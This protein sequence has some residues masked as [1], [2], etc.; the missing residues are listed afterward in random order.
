MST[1]SQ[2]FSKEDLHSIEVMDLWDEAARIIVNHARPSFVRRL[3]ESLENDPDYTREAGLGL[4]L[5]RRGSQLLVK[6]ISHQ[7]QKAA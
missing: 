7:N 4:G 2:K 3:Q 5:S 6:T 1:S